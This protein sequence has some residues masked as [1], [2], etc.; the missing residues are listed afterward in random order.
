MA[1]AG[2]SAIVVTLRQGTGTPLTP[3]LVLFTQL[4]VESSLGVAFFAMLP[5]TLIVCGL[6]ETLVW[7]ISSV[8]TLL[9]TVPYVFLYVQRRKSAAP[10]EGL[11][12]RYIFTT[13]VVLVLAALCM[14]AV[15][16]P[17]RSGPGPLAAVDVIILAATALIFVRTYVLFAR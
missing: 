5:P 4:F 16:W 17:F 7:R 1:F 6:D 13:P 3:L 8:I 15:G 11:P 14:N 9:V 10:N 12:L 2:F